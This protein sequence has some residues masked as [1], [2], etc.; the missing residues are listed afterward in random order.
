MRDDE[1]R[2]RSQS[3]KYY[4]DYRTATVI[5]YIPIILWHNCSPLL[6]CGWVHYP[7]ISVGNL[8]CDCVHSQLTANPR[9]NLF[10]EISL[11]ANI[12]YFMILCEDLHP[13]CCQSQTINGF[14]F[15]ET[16]LYTRTLFNQSNICLLFCATRF[17]YIGFF[18]SISVCYLAFSQA[19]K[20]CQK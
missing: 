15:Y 12:Y 16:P 20:P 18:H 17:H 4:C 3:M 10:T 11:N 1:L 14:P 8:F 13:D 19:V 6:K 5:K 9:G 7:L 2:N